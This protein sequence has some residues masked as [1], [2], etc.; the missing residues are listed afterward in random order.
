VLIKVNGEEIDL[1]RYGSY[2]ER[3]FDLTRSYVRRLGGGRVVE[4]GGHPWA[5][6]ARLLRD[7]N[8]KL[9]ASVSA[10]EVT[11]WPDELPVTRR[12][13]EIV[14]PDGTA[15][16]FF[17]YS[18]N[19]ERT[20]FEIGTRADLVLACEIIEHM[21]RSPHVMLLNAN[22]WLEIG[23]HLLITTPNGA[24]FQNPLHV[25]AKMPAFRY[26]TYSRHNYVFTMEG[27]T[28]LVACC[29]FEVESA[30]YHSPYGRRG[31]ARLYPIASRLPGTYFQGKFGQ[32]LYVVARKTAELKAAMRVPAVYSPSASWEHIDQSE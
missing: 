10:E 26:S 19:I 14:L 12:E 32:S 16:R 15:H 13:Y 8:V 27:L 22:A 20:L 31:L 2:H 7:P 23:G 4:L 17:N 28:D 21:T 3:R 25:R 9:V 6:T 30:E 11:A 18:A 29:G 24:Q 1:S 5:M